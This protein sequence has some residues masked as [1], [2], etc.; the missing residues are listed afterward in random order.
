M[1]RI[2]ILSMSAIMISAAPVVVDIKSKHLHNE[3]PHIPSQCYTKTKDANGDIHNPCFAC[4]IDAKEPN[5]ISDWDLQMGYS[6]R[7]YLLKNHWSNLFK[8]RSKAVLAISDEEIA[9][10]VKKSNYHDRGRLIL[11]EKLRHLPEAWDMDGDKKWDGYI[12]DCYYDFDA[13]GFDRDG[14][15]NF[16][17]WRAFGYVPVLGTFWPTNGS[18]DDV[19]IRLPKA[20]RSFGAK[21]DMDSY[22]VNLLIVEALTKQKD[23]ESF[24]IDEKRYGVDLDKD[25][26]LGV[27][28]KIAFSYDPR[29]GEYMSYVGDAKGKSKIAAGLFPKGTEF[30]HSVRYID[31]DAN[32]TIMIAP[33]MK[34]LRYA[35]KV[36]WADYNAHQ[37]LIEEELKERHDFPDRLEQFIGDNERG[38]SNKRGWRYQGFIEDD[39]G[40]LR[41]QSYEETLFCIGCHASLGAVVDSTFSFARKLEKGAYHDGWFHWSQKGLK[42]IK[43]PKTPDGRYEYTLYLE[44]NHAG[45]E[46]RD[47]D[48]VKKKFFDAKGNLNQTLVKTLHHDI[49]SLLLPSTKRATQLNKAYKV[50]VNEQS[51]IYGRDAHI[52]P[53]KSVYEEMKEGKSTGVKEPVMYY[54]DRLQR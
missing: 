16:T 22:K 43:E 48:E 4:H 30:L 13:E 40:E 32:G 35:K 25:G 11:A 31:S 6:F 9:S 39:Q 28:K 34:E 53:V 26:K 37:E 29:H 7:E 51:F 38:I 45:D 3:S 54:H 27:A 1:K 24:P 2:S 46:F 5:Y 15:G 52:K 42:G 33:R 47:N 44:Q 21:Y 23:I 20:F 19:L 17:G 49:S 36:A 10:Y 18:T 41:P 12:P 14:E 8:D 50:I